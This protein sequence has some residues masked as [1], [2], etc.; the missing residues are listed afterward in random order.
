MQRTVKFSVVFMQTLT[1]RFNQYFWKKHCRIKRIMGF[2]E[3]S[4]LLYKFR[5]TYI[6]TN[7]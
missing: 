2:L 1:V 5:F 3:T 4:A 7:V 6:L